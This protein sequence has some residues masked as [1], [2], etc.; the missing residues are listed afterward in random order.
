MI[1]TSISRHFDNL[2]TTLKQEKNTL[3]SWNTVATGLLHR[4]GTV[5]GR[6]IGYS[7]HRNRSRSRSLSR[8]LSLISVKSSAHYYRSQWNRSQSQ[9]RSLSRSRAVW[10]SHDRAMSPNIIRL[11]ATASHKYGNTLDFLQTE[12]NVQ[13]S[14]LSGKTWHLILTTKLFW[15]QSTPPQL[16]YSVQRKMIRKLSK[17]TKTAVLRSS[18]TRTQ[19]ST[20]ISVIKDIWV[21]EWG[22][23]MSPEIRNS[24]CMTTRGI[25]SAA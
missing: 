3:T 15:L 5:L 11:V 6:E 21:S 4:I 9:S 17:V 25:L 18:R 23:K 1:F 19:K 13:P 22:V 14:I 20:M 7:T 2:Q 12:T 8:S 10:E 24:S 16:T